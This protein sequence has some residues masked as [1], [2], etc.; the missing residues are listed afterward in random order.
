MIELKNMSKAYQGQ[1]VLDDLTFSVAAG[2]IIGIVGK[3]GSGKST[4]LR[5][6]NLMETPDQGTF[7]LD[8]QNTA[9]F[10]KQQTQSAKQRM[11]MVFQQYN[12]LHNLTIAENIALPLKL[13]G[14][15]NDAR[16][17]ELLAFIG[18]TAKKDT[19]PA[20]LSG[21]E[22]QRVVLA[23]ALIREPEILFCD[24]ATSSLDEENTED[25]LRLL[26]Q[27]HQKWP[28]TIFFVSHELETIQKL[29]QRVL[30]MENGRLLG[31]L[32]NLP[33]PLSQ[34][35]GSYLEKVQRRLMQ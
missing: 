13:L 14:K 32:E 8:Q 6:L 7:L 5:L 12:L 23:R 34:T 9:E 15:R 21:G 2:E 1:T 28:M 10:S 16:V 27:I 31:D 24:E 18:L 35:S 22:K 26:Q 19:Y 17:A 25:V 33:A 11:G 20:R 30:V 3:S 4:L 29:C